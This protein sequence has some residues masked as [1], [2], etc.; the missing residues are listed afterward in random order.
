MIFGMIMPMRPQ[1]GD[2]FEWIDTPGGPALVCRALEP[3]AAN[4]FTTREWTLGSS[5]ELDSNGSAAWTPV[6]NALGAPPSQLA[7]LHQVHGATVVVKRAGVRHD[8]NDLADADIIISDDRELVLAI[9][10][11]DCV[12]LLIADAKTGAVVAA[13]AG[14]RGLVARVP[15]VAIKAL[16]QHFGTR[17]SDLVVAIG[18]SIS[19]ARYEVGE[20]VRARFEA[21]GFR[22][23]HLRKWFPAETRPAHCLFDGWQS[24]RDQLAAAGVPSQGVHSADLCTSEHSEFLCSYRRD[25]RK[26]GRMAAAIRVRQR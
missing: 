11:A 12:P 6:A 23:D 13:H 20:D 4:L 21:A 15:E 25:G 24:G 16:V 17:P 5:D 2:G 8:A 1:P 18:P 19:A 26:A 9:Q 14:W 10:T 22:S 3:F 7:R